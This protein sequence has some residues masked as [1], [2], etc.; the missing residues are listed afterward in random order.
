MTSQ[1]MMKCKCRIGHWFVNIAEVDE[2]QNWVEQPL[3][4]QVDINSNTIFGYEQK[5][6]LARQYKNKTRSNQNDII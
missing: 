1:E 3:P 6:F 2:P 5:A 4:Y